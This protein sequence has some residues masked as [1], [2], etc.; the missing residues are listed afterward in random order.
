MQLCQ[1]RRGELKEMHYL[2]TERVEI[3]YQMPLGEII[4]DFFDLLKSSDE[5]IRIA[6]LRARRSKP[7]NLVRVDVLLNQQ[8]VDAFSTIVHRDKAY[9]YGKTMT[10]RLRKLIPR[11]L[12]DVPIQA[13]IGSRVIARET[14]KAKTKGRHRQVLRRR[15]HA[16]AQAA[17]APE[18][19]QAAHEADR[20][21]RGALRPRSS[22]RCAWTRREHAVEEG[23]RSPDASSGR[24]LDR[25]GFGVY[26]HIPFCRHRCHYCDFNTY[27]GMDDQYEAYVDALVTDID[28]WDGPAPDATSV[29][30]GGGTPTLLPVES[31]SRI[32]EAV[33]DRFGF[34]P[35]P[36]ITIEANPEGVDERVFEGLLLAGFNRVSFGVQSLVP[37]VLAGLGR[38]HSPETARLAIAAARNAG[39]EDVNADLIYGSPWESTSDWLVS[40]EGILEIDPDHVS[41][42]ALTIEEGTP[43]ATLVTTGRVPDV[44]PDL[45]AERHAAAEALLGAA[46]FDRYEISNWARP[47]RACR[48]NVLYWSAGDYAGFGAGAHGHIAGRRS[49]AR[50]LPR[51]FIGAVAAGRLDRSG[52]RGPRSRRSLR[53]GAHARTPSRIRAGSG[54]RGPAFRDRGTGRTVARRRG[55]LRTGPAGASRPPCECRPVG[56]DGHGRYLRPFAL[57]V[58]ILR[59]VEWVKARL[60][61]VDI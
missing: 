52:R 2:S 48:H 12:F 3:R 30:F 15:R 14:V 38:T 26:V 43:L 23:C 11:Q 17:R 4:F 13:A 44:D 27:E 49:W 57:V 18:R 56:H 37:S 20:L 53:R 40:L 32:L 28:R 54:R 16:E 24:W 59:W 36:E 31:L 5:G 7:I 34:A 35:D 1:D 22:R 39:F 9:D 41:A 42:Y 47:G 55:A 45:Q 33:R 21:R 6:R 46:G 50:R 61:S 8:P 51:E 60:N 10:E 29:F 58:H 25:P 19:G